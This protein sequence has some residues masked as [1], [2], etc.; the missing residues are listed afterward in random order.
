MKPIHMTIEEAFEKSK[1]DIIGDNLIITSLTEAEEL[2]DKFIQLRQ[3]LSIVGLQII[4]V[5]PHYRGEQKFGWDIRPGIFRPP[6]N[7]TDPQIGKQLEKK[8]IHEFEKTITEKV[9]QKVL[10]DIFNKE[11]HGKDW[12]LLFQAQHAG[13][14]TTLTDWTPNIVS[15]MYFATEQSTDDLIE[16][17]DGQLWSFI[18]PTENILGHN[19][20]PVRNSFYD[21]DPFD[22][23]ATF[24][25]NPS[26]YLDDI[27]KRIFEYRMYRQKGRFIMPSNDTCHIPLNQQDELKKFI[28]QARIPAEHKAKIREELA[29]RG[30]DRN[31]T[32]IDENPQ[33]QELI[34]EI[35]S[36]IF[37]GY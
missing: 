32:Y 3:K 24:L 4:D 36:I 33:R 31:S 1:H 10:R 2:Y 13:V 22:V 19:D 35:N 34:T 12:D 11:T 25:I 21:I 9:G 27:D 37:K 18:V 17:S 26:S 30:V 20:Y 8:A 5:M 15:A 28:F 14:K 6:L 23:K 16:K 7:I 29:K